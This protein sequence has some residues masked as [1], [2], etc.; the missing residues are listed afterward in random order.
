MRQRRG[1]GVAERDLCRGPARLAQALGIDGDM[2]G[3][4]LCSAEDSEG[5]VSE[6]VSDGPGIRDDQRNHSALTARIWLEAG[7]P[8]PADRIRQGPRI[9]LGKTP[10]PWLSMPWR[11]TA[12]R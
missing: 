1:L 11:R 10:E 9:G 8:P 4:D 6:G 5:V 7:H 2:S 12:C 3:L